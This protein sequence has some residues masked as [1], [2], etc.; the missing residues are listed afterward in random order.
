MSD[1]A[2]LKQ[3][4]AAHYVRLGNA[5]AAARLVFPDEPGKSLLVGMAWMNDP[6][7]LAFMAELKATVPPKALI[8]TKE[9]LLRELWTI[10]TDRTINRDTKDRIAALAKFAD[11]AGY[12]EKSG[13]GLNLSIGLTNKVMVVPAEQSLDD[14]EAKAKKQQANLIAEAQP[15]SNARH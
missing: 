15:V 7:V 13:N 2:A 3:E 1:D 14:W 5:D 6:D 11:V 12:I 8:P 10:G 9:D 4:F